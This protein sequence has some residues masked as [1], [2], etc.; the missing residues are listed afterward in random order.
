M[1]QK[2]TTALVLYD[3]APTI[4]FQ[5]PSGDEAYSGPETIII[6]PDRQETTERIPISAVLRRVISGILIGSALTT[7]G[8]CAG[9]ALSDIPLDRED[10]PAFFMAALSAGE[11]HTTPAAL[12]RCTAPAPSPDLPVSPVE[13]PQQTD[14]KPAREPSPLT[15]TNETPYTPDPFSLAENRAIPSLDSLKA[16]YGSDAPFVLILSTHATESYSGHESEGYRTSDDSE[17]VIRTA[18]VIAQTLEE[19]GIGVIHCRT[20]FD[21][22][23]FTLAYYNASLEIRAQLR[24]HPSVQYIIDVHRDS[25]QAADGTYMAMESDGLAQMMFV[26]GT[27]H[28]GSGHTEWEDNLGLAARLHTA[29]EKE[30]PG[31]MRPLNLRSASFNQQYTK[32][33]LILEI[34]SCAGSLENAVKSARLFGKAFADEIIG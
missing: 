27:D 8:I 29:L 13:Y 26:V 2:E 1:D 10:V 12:Y 23:D 15:L 9:H 25:V 30:N 20:R 17:N 22:E 28:G 33:S 32:G 11:V 24:D 5:L 3:N 16:E 31:V 18:S 21:E 19:A 4:E 7:A 6:E 34:G 14:P